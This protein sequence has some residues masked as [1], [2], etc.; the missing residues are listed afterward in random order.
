MN[1][2]KGYPKVKV[3]LIKMYHV[4]PPIYL[5]YLGWRLDPVA[6]FEAATAAEFSF[7]TAAEG[8][9]EAACARVS[10]FVRVD[11]PVRVITPLSRSSPA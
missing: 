2:V 6:V 7:K 1:F 9:L 10:S 4:Y 11:T 8:F 5:Y 3:T